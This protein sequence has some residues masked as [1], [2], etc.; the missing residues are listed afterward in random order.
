MKKI[1]SIVIVFMLFLSCFAKEMQKLSSADIRELLEYSDVYKNDLYAYYMDNSGDLAIICYLGESVETLVV[2]EKIEG[3]PV[4]TILSL[5]S[6]NNAK[7]KNVIIPKSVI[8]IYDN[9]CVELGIEKL[10]FEKDSNLNRI[11]VN[12]FR[13]NEIKELNLPKKQLSIGFDSF[14]DNKIKKI[15]VYKDWVFQYHTPF[16]KFS[17]DYCSTQEDN[18]FL[19]SDILEEVIFEEGC[20]Y[21]APKCFAECHNLKKL[22]IPST[23]KKF[24]AYAF[25]D[26]TSLSEISFA[27]VSIADV[28]TLEELYA[29]AK[30]QF[31]PNDDILG[32]GAALESY[33]RLVT[34]P[35]SAVK[36]FGNCPI[37]LKTKRTLL[38]MGL[39]QNAF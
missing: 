1:L 26:C 18:A 24:G 30:L 12:A 38:K 4:G 21:I 37:G 27:G 36:T 28:D 14:S 11:G 9:A 20:F 2:P 19:K 29:K 7:F 16:N 23:M 8:T 10:S 13:Y 33:T 22:A 32:L 5:Q 39:P 17:L 35:W 15:S 31:D 25:N 34:D 6:L 3:I